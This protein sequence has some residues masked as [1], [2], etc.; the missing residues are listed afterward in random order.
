MNQDFRL[1]PCVVRPS[2]NIIAFNGKVARV[3]P[4]AMEVLVCLATHAPNVVSKE[5]LIGT[6]WANTFVGDDVLTR[7]ISELRKTFDDDPK[8]PRVIET[9]AVAGLPVVGKGRTYR[10]VPRLD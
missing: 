9:I 10:V 4:K 1:G 2:L 3:E 6:V 8:A 5:Q 7:C